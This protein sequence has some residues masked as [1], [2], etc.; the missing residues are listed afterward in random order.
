MI[1]VARRIYLKAMINRGWSANYEGENILSINKNGLS[2]S[3]EPGGQLEFST[4]PIL[5]VCSIRDEI[6]KFYSGCY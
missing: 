4:D 1:R 5:D 3:T 2:I 6:L